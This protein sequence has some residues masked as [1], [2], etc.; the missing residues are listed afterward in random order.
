MFATMYLFEQSNQCTNAANCLAI[1]CGPESWRPTA[2]KTIGKCRRWWILDHVCD[3]VY[4]KSKCFD[5]KRC[6]LLGN[7]LW[8]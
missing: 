3:N 2:K 6:K 1:Y 5:R 7:L 4:F 8:S